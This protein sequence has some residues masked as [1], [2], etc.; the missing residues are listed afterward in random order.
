MSAKSDAK[1]AE[2]L[3]HIERAQRELEAA[4][5]ALSS[6]IGLAQEWRQVSKLCTL[7]KARWY[8]LERLRGGKHRMDWER[9]P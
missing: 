1:L 9:K 8:H 3:Q 4:C 7:V 6:V 5:Q 2:A